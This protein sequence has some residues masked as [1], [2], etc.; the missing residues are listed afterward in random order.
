[1]NALRSIASRSTIGLPRRSIAYGIQIQLQLDLHDLRESD[2]GSK[3]AENSASGDHKWVPTVTRGPWGPPEN[4]T[5]A[6][7]PLFAL[8]DGLDDEMIARMVRRAP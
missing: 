6:I 1:M 7:I 2:R 4:G 5:P 8:D 3:G